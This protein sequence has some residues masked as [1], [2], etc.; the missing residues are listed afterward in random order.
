MLQSCY[1]TKIMPLCVLKE[2][3]GI[4]ILWR[5]SRRL[6]PLSRMPHLAC[7]IDI[8]VLRFIFSNGLLM[9]MED[10]APWASPVDPSLSCPVENSIDQ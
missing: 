8:A 1:R 2:G 3:R 4:E 5:W 6:F 10:A 9:S 7:P